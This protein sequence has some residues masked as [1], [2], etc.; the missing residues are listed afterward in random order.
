MITFFVIVVAVANIMQKDPDV[1]FLL[2]HNN[3]KKTKNS[4]RTYT[5][6]FIHPKKSTE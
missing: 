4:A 1:D 5:G 6:T 3:K 2:I